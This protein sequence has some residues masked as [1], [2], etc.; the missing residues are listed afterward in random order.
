[1]VLTTT[2]QAA[3]A[4]SLDQ[5][6]KLFEQDADVLTRPLGGGQAGFT[7]TPRGAPVEFVFEQQAGKVIAGL[8]QDSVDSVL[9]PTQTLGST[10]GYKAA[11][12]SLQGLTPSFYLDFKP[13]TTILDIP[14]VS[15]N[16]NLQL[17]RPY[18]DRLDYLVAGTGQKNG[19]TL[20]RIVL[21]VKAGGAGSG[22]VA[23]AGAPPYAA[24]TP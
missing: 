6:Q 8:G 23:S 5:L 12:S 1:I 22:S 16:P 19:R 9:N 4:K 10:S 24:V 17:A 11:A 13:I 2:D 15:T 18:L 7:V 21:G 20:E 3:S 14:G